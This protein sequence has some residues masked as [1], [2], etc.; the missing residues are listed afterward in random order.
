MPRKP[1][2]RARRSARQERSQETVQIVLEAGAQVLCKRGYAGATTNHI[3]EAAGV[4]VGTIYQYFASKDDL[5][6]ALV[7]NYFTEVIERVGA[8]PIDPWLPFEVSVRKAV[9]RGLLAQ[10]FGPQILR[11]LEQVPNAVLRRRLAEG[12]QEVIV[13]FRELLEAYRDSLRP[14]DLD[15]AATLLLNASEGIGYN[16]PQDRYDQRLIDELTSLIVRYLV[17]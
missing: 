7:R 3:A 14:I 6:D 9:E 11:A 12:K 4:S 10:R 13:Y 15:R 5:F 8:D 1:P 17:K 16:E 2:E